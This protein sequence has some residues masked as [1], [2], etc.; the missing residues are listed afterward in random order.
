MWV[1]LGLGFGIAVHAGC[2][3]LGV[4]FVASFVGFVVLGV[5]IWFEMWF[6]R[7]FVVA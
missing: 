3:V 2:R 4:P 7:V 1:S 5:L 6:V